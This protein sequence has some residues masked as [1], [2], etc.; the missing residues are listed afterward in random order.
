MTLHE[1]KPIV[2]DKRVL[3]EYM[4]TKEGCGWQYAWVTTEEK[5]WGYEDIYPLLGEFYKELRR[6]N[7]KDIYV[8]WYNARTKETSY[9]YFKVI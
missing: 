2:M 8:G 7:F 5:S 6:T 9:E 4:L 1:E 3:L